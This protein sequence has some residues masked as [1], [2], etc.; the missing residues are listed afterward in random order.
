VSAGRAWKE[1]PWPGLVES[2]GQ[3]VGEW[4]Y[5]LSL[6]FAVDDERPADDVWNHVILGVHLGDLAAT[7]SEFV[8]ETEHQDDS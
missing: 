7:H 4:E 5:P 2:V 8:R 6:A 3:V 1:V